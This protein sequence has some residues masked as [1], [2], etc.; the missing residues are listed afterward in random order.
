MLEDMR[1]AAAIAF[2]QFVINCAR[3]AAGQAAPE[4]VIWEQDGSPMIRIPAGAFEMGLT[5]EEARAAWQEDTALWAQNLKAAGWPA[6]RLEDYLSATPKHRTS[7]SAFLL[8][9]YEV[10]NAQYRKYVAATGARPA[11]YAGDPVLGRDEHPVVGVSWRD[12]TAYARWA[13]KRLPTEAEWEYAAR[14]PTGLMY[15]WGG[16]LEATRANLP[17]EL[18][19]DE[20]AQS[21]PRGSFSAGASPFGILDLCGNAME[22]VADPFD[23]RYYAH[24]PTSDPPGPATGEFR[25]LRGG[26]WKYFHSPAIYRSAYRAPRYLGDRA[27]FAGFRC[28]ADD[29]MDGMEF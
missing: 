22:W 4:I 20:Y 27:P 9:Q 1:P 19:P 15:P 11:E 12:A 2:F 21:A 5:E 10:S 29:R 6:P 25:I 8:D 13:G 7:V 17:V 24:S 18:S 28:A 23:A 14:G 3:I 16:I 26:G